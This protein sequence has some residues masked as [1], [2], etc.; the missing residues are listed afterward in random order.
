MCAEP[1]Q[2]DF[3]W[4]TGPQ[5]YAAI[6]ANLITLAIGCMV[7]WFSPALAKLT[8]KDTPL[9]EGPLNSEQISWLGSISNLS[10]LCGI[11]VTGIFIKLLG[12]KNAMIS[13]AF[14]STA[15]WIL[16]YFGNSYYHLLI[17]KICAG[18]TGGGSQATIV[19]YIS[20]IA[21][22]DIRGRLG[23]I[24]T[25]LVNIGILS[26]YI[27]GAIVDYEYVPC[28]FIAI[29]LIYV[30]CF[31]F[32]P[33]TPQY[34][35]RRGR[36][37]EAEKSLRYFKGFKGDPKQIKA[38]NIEFERLKSVSKEHNTDQKLQINDFSEFL[39]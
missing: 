21:N 28:I 8:S 2:T 3:K 20:E 22:D 29:P 39:H 11:F 12:C 31:A 27:V 23:S 13:L 14:P 15:F 37:E 10:A 17:A 33:N 9:I 38:F 32:I 30:A 16:I 25:L 1:K 4:R 18:W 7:G 19:L 5:Y 34:C 26:G 6:A 24:I 35:L 36:I